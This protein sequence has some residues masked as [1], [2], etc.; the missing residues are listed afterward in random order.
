MGGEPTITSNPETTYC[1]IDGIVYGKGAANPA[2]PSTC[3]QPLELTA[4]WSTSCNTTIGGVGGATAAGG[5]AGTGCT[6]NFEL[7]Q[8][9]SGLCVAKMATITAPSG[10]PNYGIDVTEV[11][12]GQYDSWLATNPA[13]PPSTDANCGYL[14]SYAEQSTNG[15]YAGPDVD[16]HPVVFVDWCD[17]YAYC[18]GVGKRLCGAIGGGPADATSQWYEACSSGGT[19]AYPYGNSYQGSYC[20][21][22]DYGA[23]Q[24]VAVG[25]LAECVTSTPGYAGVYDLSGNVSEWIDSCVAG[26]VESA[27]CAIVGGG[28]GYNLYDDPKFVS[29]SGVVERR[30]LRGGKR[31]GVSLLLFPMMNVVCWDSY[32]GSGV[33]PLE[34][35]QVPK[36]RLPLPVSRCP[37][38]CRCLVD[39]SCCRPSTEPCRRSE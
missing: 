27:L 25:S 5:S 7:V 31:H 22:F 32:S 14:A 37:R 2:D 10:Y 36:T 19:D 8:G 13:L 16:H 34:L 4:S 3:C 28:F 21:G 33:R 35:R 38:S 17:A 11:T 29:C 30:P 12:S 26:S 9:G 23:G 24:T 39:R 6:G 20:N 15:V 18:K 1:T